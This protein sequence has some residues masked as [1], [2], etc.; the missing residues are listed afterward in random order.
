M[1]V[2]LKK[3]E[4]VSL[5]KTAGAAGLTKIRV[6]LGWD[7][8]QTVGDQF[9][10]DASAFMLKADGK[11][12]NERDFVFYGDGYTKSPEGAVEY[13]GDNRTGQGDGDDEFIL[14]DL[15]KVPDEIKKIAITV[16]IDEWE[17][18]RQ[19]FGQVT[20]AYIRVVNEADNTELARYDL[21]E[22]F[23]T[24][25][26]LVFGEVYNHNGEWKFSAVGQGFPGG[27]GDLCASYGVATE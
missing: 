22:D 24:E 17:A 12:R 7:R 5:T 21:S 6:G 20:N 15:P 19:S 4:K 16:T 11:V 26:A 8:R 14:V 27:L 1:P 2:S 3:G 18:R 25:T 10:L 23:S 13:G 9:D